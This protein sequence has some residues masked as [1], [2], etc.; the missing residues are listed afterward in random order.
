MID[1]EAECDAAATRH[2]P[3]KRSALGGWLV[4]A[5]F[6]CIA[7][8][9]WP[10][11]PWRASVPGL[12]LAAAGTAVAAWTLAV[13]RPGNFNIRPEAKRDGRLITHGPYACVRHPMYS[14]LILVV[15]GVV[16]QHFDGIRACATAAL[17][18]VLAIKSRV[19]E[20]SL[21]EAFDGYAAYAA[22]A[23]R[24]VPR[25]GRRRRT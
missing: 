12:A 20:R 24:F 7:A 22:G 14:A 3:M 19:E 18:G 9:L 4:A 16:M 23:G 25:I 8:A 1:A 6:A 15:A 2:V 17:I 10:S 11:G 13:N 5:Q 21:R